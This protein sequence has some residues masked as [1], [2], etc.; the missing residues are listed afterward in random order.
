MNRSRKAFTLVEVLLV[1]MTLPVIAIVI[2][3]IFATFIQD[4][5]RA[6][7]MVQQNTPVLDMVHR[8]QQ[9]V[10]R[11]VGLPDS[12]GDKRT[13]ERTLLIALPGQVVCYQ[14]EDGAISRTILNDDNE[15]P[16][17]EGQ[18]R[19]PDAVVTWQRWRRDTT[20]YAVE[21]RTLVRQRMGSKM[22]DMLANAHLFFVPN[23]A[24]GDQS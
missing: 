7:R 14:Q 21:V 13:D 20:P 19:F 6:T 5:P 10:D 22:K 4:I 11:A 24:E 2:S 12:F 15:N 8:M 17:I 1:I 3:H 9:D 23:K 16:K 18:W